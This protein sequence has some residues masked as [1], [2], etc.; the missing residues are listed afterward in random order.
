MSKKRKLY[1]DLNLINTN[2]D[3]IQ[4]NS[5]FVH[6]NSNISSSY[7]D[8]LLHKT[9]QD[10]S[11]DETILLPS[12]NDLS[13]DTNTKNPFNNDDKTTLLSSVNDKLSDEIHDIETMD[14]NISKYSNN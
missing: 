13:Y 11:D 10:S 14:E 12:L 2:E 4:N 1:N 6:K 9:K 5:N 8:N 3:N 7:L